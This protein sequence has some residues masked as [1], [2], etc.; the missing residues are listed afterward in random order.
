MKGFYNSTMEDFMLFNPAESIKKG[1]MAKKIPMERLSPF[2]RKINGFEVA[3]YTSGPKFRNG[4][5]LLAKITPCLE[6]G[7]TAF[8]D[9]LGDNEVAFG[10]SEFIVLREKQGVSDKEFVYYLAKS[11]AFRERA[12]GCM[13]GTSGRKRVNDKS[14][15][16]HILPVPDLTTQRRIAAV[17]SSLDAKI[18]LNRQI[19]DNLEAM[20]KDIYNY[21]FLQNKSYEWAVE[22]LGNLLKKHSDTSKHI[23]AK[24]ILTAGKFP[25]I[26][27]DAGELIK[28]YSNE[29]SPISNIPCIVFGDHS[30]TLRF[31]NFPFFRGADGTQLLYF[32]DKLI[33]YVY[34]FLENVI[35]Q[36]PNYGKYERHF[37]YIKE[38]EL[39]IPTT[40][41]LT[42]FQKQIHPLFKKILAT[43]QQSTELARLRDYLLPLLMNGQVSVNYHL[44]DY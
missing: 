5:T 38:L 42:E 11:P 39:P 2:A 17:L 24:E 6:N 10:S 15:K 8:V 22:K 13:E 19:N 25:V 35:S 21:I 23:E 20:A 32:E 44:S 1:T 28:G 27:Q 36:I 26:T 14:L 37:K 7:K 12:I 43:Q 33:E 29:K 40:E 30:C 18:A 4:D 31:I 9:V 41:I 34:F 16:Q 3:T